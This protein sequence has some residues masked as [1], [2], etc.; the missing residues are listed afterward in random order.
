MTSKGATDDGGDS[1]DDLGS[2]LS[3]DPADKNGYTQLVPSGYDPDLVSG[4]VAP[5]IHVSGPNNTH[6]TIALQS[7]GPKGHIDIGDDGTVTEYSGTGNKND[8]LQTSPD[9]ELK[10]AKGECV[11]VNS[12]NAP[13]AVQ[14][15]ITDAQGLTQE[16]IG[17]F[18]DKTSQ[19]VTPYPLTP[20]NSSIDAAEPEGERLHSHQYEID[21]GL[22]CHGHDDRGE[23]L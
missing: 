16:M 23:V 6:K 17:H 5:T 11:I 19:V 13:P 21:S 7:V 2:S 3:L 20:S 18:G 15:A 10:P 9:S 4:K 1:A 22:G 14:A 12:S 8:V